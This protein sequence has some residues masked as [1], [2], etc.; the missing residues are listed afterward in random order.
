MDL[1]ATKK[2]VMAALLLPGLVMGAEAVLLIDGALN[3]LRI[4][5][6]DKNYAYVTS[7][8]GRLGSSTIPTEAHETIRYLSEPGET[9]PV[10]LQQARGAVDR[11]FARLMTELAEFG[12]KRP[13]LKTYGE[14]L[15]L[16]VDGIHRYRIR[17]DN[18]N[19]VTEEII[20]RYKPASDINVDL[21]GR[22]ALRDRRSG[23]VPQ[24][25]HVRQPAQGKR[26]G[27][28]CRLLRNGI[29]SRPHPVDRRPGHVRP[30]GG[31][32]E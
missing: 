3:R 25:S 13:V 29:S 15:R 12:D 6:A 19:A 4:L 18:S 23:A 24:A 16:A 21:V 2:V 9:N 22:S 10:R 31:D 27:L 7:D 20:G 26:V 30:G 32:E 11:D 28:G 14:R 1:K 5:E 17:V 8:A